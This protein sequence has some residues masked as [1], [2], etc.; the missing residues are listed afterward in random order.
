MNDNIVSGNEVCGLKVIKKP[1]SSLLLNKALNVA[2]KFHLGARGGPAIEN[3]LQKRNLSIESQAAN[4]HL[5]LTL[6]RKEKNSIIY[7]Q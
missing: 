7:N 6:C 5:T 2:N 4:S 3:K 1:F